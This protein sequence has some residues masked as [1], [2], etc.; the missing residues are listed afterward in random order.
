MNT[1]VPI[2]QL[3]E[4][5]T[6]PPNSDYIVNMGDG[7]GTKRV[8][9]ETLVKEVKESAIDILDSKE[10]IEANT[11]E[12]KIAGAL[13]VKEKIEEIST[14]LNNIKSYSAIFSGI[15]VAAG[16]NIFA[17]VLTVPPGLYIVCVDAR[18]DTRI[19]Q[20]RYFVRIDGKSENV[21][22][23]ISS[24]NTSHVYFTQ[25]I[26][27]TDGELKLKVYNESANDIKALMGSLQAVRLK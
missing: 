7:S 19:T 25:I 12:G 14:L 27:V 18:S 23:S 4:S 3:E 9:Q 16:A 20:G 15:N 24:N 22:N 21:E 1:G 11:D 5:K 2:L 13:G 26:Q 17:A 10:E 8:T 6:I